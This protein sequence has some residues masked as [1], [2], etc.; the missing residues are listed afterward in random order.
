MWREPIRF[1][2]AALDGSRTYVMGVLNVTPDSFSDGGQHL[3]PAAA[4]ARAEALIAEGS[5]LLDVGAEST[6][7][8]A[9]PVDA[10]TE[11]ARL[12]PVLQGLRGAPVPISVDTYKAEVAER[13]LRAGAEVVNDISGG[14]IDPGLLG[15][16]ARHGAVAVLSHLRGRPATM[17]EQVAFTDV[18]EEVAE[19][20]G[21][22]LAR[23]RA[24]G[25]RRIIADPGIGFGKLAAQNLILLSRAGELS[26]RL[27]VPVLVGPSRKAFLGALT[28]L[29]VE[30]RGPA[31]LAAVV[32][33][34]MGGAALVRV[35][36]VAP[37]RQALAVADAA[38]R[39]VDATTGVGR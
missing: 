22:V 32:T 27:G 15:V 19:E 31:T 3:A 28:G 18:F 16:C 13:A 26:R 2:A 8:G 14:Q 21:A 12:A 9:Q 23:A 39:V 1:R 5:D 33:A 11:W 37:A 29:P 4:L 25:V 10:A 24:A 38:A 7:P 30:R 20:L 36:D 6:R 17:M 34:A 35:H